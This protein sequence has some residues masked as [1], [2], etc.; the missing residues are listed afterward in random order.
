MGVGDVLGNVA[1]I[2]I[3]ASLAV[4]FYE[5]SNDLGEMTVIL[6]EAIE[7]P[8]TF[9]TGLLIFTFSLDT[10][11]P[12]IPVDS[13]PFYLKWLAV[14]YFFT[15]GYLPHFSLWTALFALVFSFVVT[16]IVLRVTSWEFQWR[17]VLVA[18][19]SFVG[20]WYVWHLISWLGMGFGADLMGLGS[21]TAYTIWRN[22][23]S[24]TDGPLLQYFFFGTIPL[25]VYLL[26][27][28]VGTRLF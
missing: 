28:K 4:G 2:V 20:C 21:E 1:L 5:S 14:P 19:V 22:A 25:S 12:G 27:Q 10:W 17:G 9:G 3:I 16:C 11:T 6:D 13:L 8:T 24:S 26:Y 7:A 15:D 18:I 23:V